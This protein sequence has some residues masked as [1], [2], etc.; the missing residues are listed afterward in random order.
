MA[1]STYLS[2]KVLATALTNVGYTG[3]VTVYAA[4]FNGDPQGAG[5]EASGGSYA[6]QPIVFS[7]PSGGA[8]ANTNIPTFTNMPAMTANYTAL[9]DAVTG[10]NIL[11]SQADTTPKTINA[12]DTVS[13]AIGAVTVGES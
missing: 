7:T 5:T 4:I 3:P 12:G 1:K 6:R 11:Y 13:I 10:G 2:N 9:Y 8:T